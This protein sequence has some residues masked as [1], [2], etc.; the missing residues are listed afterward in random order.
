MPGYEL[1][2]TFFFLAEVKILSPSYPKDPL[3]SLT[4]ISYAFHLLCLVSLRRQNMKLI[5]HFHFEI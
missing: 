5:I 4:F 2:I 3:G 1:K